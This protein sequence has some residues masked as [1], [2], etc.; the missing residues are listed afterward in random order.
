MNVV[1]SI[2]TDEVRELIIRPT[3]KMLNVWSEAAECLLLTTAIS[4]SENDCCDQSQK[5]RHYG[6]YRINPVTHLNVWDKYLVQDPDLASKVRGLAS[7][8]SFL[9]NP[10]REL[11]TNLAYATAIA[12]MIYQRCERPLPEL[13]DADAMARYWKRHFHNGKPVDESCFCEHY[14]QQ[15]Q[16]V[17]IAA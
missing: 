13:E 17:D 1:C 10:H 12:W 2:N 14:R 4:E 9:E 11:T 6:L 3:L 15:L 5:P 7:Q 8:R 16:Q